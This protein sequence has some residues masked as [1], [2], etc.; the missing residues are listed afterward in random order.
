MRRLAW[1]FILIG[2]IVQA[3]II[4]AA[5]SPSAWPTLDY[6]PHIQI[7]LSYDGSPEGVFDYDGAVVRAANDCASQSANT[8]PV[9][10]AFTIKGSVPH[11]RIFH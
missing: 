7:R 10:A 2:I 11:N 1:I 9:V 4:S 6:D 8:H 5:A 3:L